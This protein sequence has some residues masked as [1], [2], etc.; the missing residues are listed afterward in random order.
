MI[1]GAGRR[2]SGA[3]ALAFAVS[4]LSCAAGS[5]PPE[6]AC[7]TTIWARPEGSAGAP[8]W[9]IGSWNDWAAAGTPLLA[10]K[11]GLHAATLELPPGEYGYQVVESGAPRLDAFNPQ[12]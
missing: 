8:L 12:S 3:A 9:V 11:D 7:G 6:R 10:Q 5:A 1:R 4:S 2:M